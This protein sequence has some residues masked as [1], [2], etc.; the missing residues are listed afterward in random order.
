MVCRIDETDSIR[1][2]PYADAHG[3]VLWESPLN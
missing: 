1:S 2:Q 3:V